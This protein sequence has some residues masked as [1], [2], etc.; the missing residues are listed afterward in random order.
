MEEIH[1]SPCDCPGRA[2]AVGR[3][4]KIVLWWLT[5][6]ELLLLA[7]VASVMEGKPKPTCG[8]LSQE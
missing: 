3:T 7:V 1:S 4:L 8:G 5:E 6:L 2:S